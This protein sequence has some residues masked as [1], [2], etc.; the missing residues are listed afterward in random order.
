MMVSLNGIRHFCL[1]VRHWMNVRQN[2]AVSVKNNAL[3]QNQTRK[4]IGVV[5]SWRE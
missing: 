1:W 2:I 4:I 5:A 3:Y